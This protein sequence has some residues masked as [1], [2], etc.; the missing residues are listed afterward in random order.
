MN[1]N[2]LRIQAIKMSYRGRDQEM[3][4]KILDARD[5]K[6]RE[7]RELRAKAALEELKSRKKEN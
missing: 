2:E 3:S 7:A 4:K 5:K 1:E 6:I